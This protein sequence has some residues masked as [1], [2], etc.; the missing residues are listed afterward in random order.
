MVKMAISSAA[1]ALL[2]ALIDRA[3]VQRNRILLTE[4]SSIDWQSLT[5]TGERHQLCLRVTGVD[6]DEIANRMCSGLAEAEFSIPGWLVADVALAG[7]P[8]RAP[9]G[10]T[11]FEIEALTILKD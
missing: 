4:A 6:S 3:R 2:R 5:F 1:S 9:D 11:E 8:R 7:T 10:A